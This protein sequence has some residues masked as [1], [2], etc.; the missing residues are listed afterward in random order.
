MN[1]IHNTIANYILYKPLASKLTNRHVEIYLRK[2]NI[3]EI[4]LN[5]LSTNLIYGKQ[6]SD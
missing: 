5:G 1:V 2:T 4:A 6:T 3:K